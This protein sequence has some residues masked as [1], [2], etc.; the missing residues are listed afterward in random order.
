MMKLRENKQFVT[1]ILVSFLLGWGIEFVASVLAKKGAAIAYQILLMA[2]MY[3][4]SVAVLLSHA[5]IK[6]MGWKPQIRKNIKY[7]MLAW[8]APIILTAIGAA[9]YFMFF[10][11]H[12]DLSGASLGAE[13]L[14]Q[15]ES[16]GISYPAYILISIVGCFTYA[17]F[18]NMFLALGEEIGWR[19]FLYPW[20]KA[21]F[22][23]RRGWLLGG[24]IWG[25]WHWPLIGLIGYEYGT[26]YVGFPLTGMLCFCIFSVVIGI[27]CD[28][29]YERSGSIWLPS[30][31][32]GAINA[33]G[34]VPLAVCLS[35]TASARLL[36]P[37][38][39]GMIAGLPFL[40]L[41][42]LIF[43]QKG[44]AGGADK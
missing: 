34:T 39:N 25:T 26:D 9:M 40:V 24:I 4:P 21:K 27:L 11:K 22:G 32:H 44:R 13:V 38:P 15:L 14:K 31:L 19:G 33:A 3:V 8:F 35:G 2:L 23:S 20:L 7:I 16:Q 37:A 36:G 10:P 41:S 28:W 18:L 5:P 43:F 30:L 12:F 6:I 42:L 17:P 29:L 1:F